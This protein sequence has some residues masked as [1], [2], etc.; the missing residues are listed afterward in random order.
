MAFIKKCDAWAARR[1]WPVRWVYL[2]VKW[3]LVALGALMVILLWL[4]RTGLRSL[5]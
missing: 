1:A 3:Y 2:G 5:Y 4:D